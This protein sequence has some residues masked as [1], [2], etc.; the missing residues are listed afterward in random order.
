MHVAEA[1][2]EQARQDAIERE[3]AAKKKM[4]EA[5]EAARRA[6]AE[7]ARRA[8]AASAAAAAKRAAE[9]VA[10][11]QKPRSEPAL[12]DAP[13]QPTPQRPRPSCHSRCVR[14]QRS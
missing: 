1:C 9:L 8:T 7:E 11:L 12:R 13:L 2:Q 4:A 10:K 6:K 3:R 5:E 14:W